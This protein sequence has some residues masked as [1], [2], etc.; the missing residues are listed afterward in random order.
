[1][2]SKVQQSEGRALTYLAKAAWR[3][4]WTDA[5]SHFGGVGRDSTVTR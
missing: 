4:A 3:V 2:A 1:M 5:A